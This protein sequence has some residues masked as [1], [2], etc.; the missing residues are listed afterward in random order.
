MISVG[1]IAEFNPFHNGHKYIIEKIKERFEDSII[2][3]IMSGNFTQRGDS[4][5]INKW[6]KTKVALKNNIDLV[7]ELPSEFTVQGADDFAYASIKILK[8]LN[9]NYLVFGSESN[10]LEKLEEAAST[11]LNNNYNSKIKNE[12]KKGI[13]YPTALNNSLDIKITTPN[14]ILALSYI[15]EIKKQNANIIPISIKRTNSYHDKKLNNKI[16]SA[17]SI[18]E[19]IKKTSIKK[20]MPKSRFFRCSF[21]L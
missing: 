20:Y 6:D 7:V 10:D 5:L 3:V 8:E 19:N 21:R 18:R 11:Q 16:T 12:L 15:R 14:D 9:V 17:T 13:S 2:I 1:L 4:S